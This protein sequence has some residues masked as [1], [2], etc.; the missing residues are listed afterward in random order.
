ME[1][2]T[3][4]VEATDL[5][6]QL[7]ETNAKLNKLIDADSAEKAAALVAEDAKKAVVTDVK[8]RMPAT[9]FVAKE[10]GADVHDIISKRAYVTDI[11][12]KR[13]YYDDE[14][15]GYMHLFGKAMRAKIHENKQDF[16]KFKAAMDKA[17]LLSCTIT[18][19]QL[20]ETAIPGSLWVYQELLPTYLRARDDGTPYEVFN[21]VTV[22]QDT[23]RLP[24][25]LTVPTFTWKGEKEKKDV[26]EP[27]GTQLTWD[28]NWLAGIMLYTNDLLEDAYSV[29]LTQYMLESAARGMRNS[30]WAATAVGNG[31]GQPTGYENCDYT[32]HEVD[33]AGSLTYPI[34]KQSWLTLNHPYRTAPSTAWFCNTWGLDAILDVVDHENRPVYGDMNPR[35]GAY[36]TPHGRPI[37][38]NE[39]IATDADSTPDVTSIY[40]IDTA[41]YH[42]FKRAGAGIRIDYSKDA[43]VTV[44]STDY[45]LFQ[46]NMGA[47]R[48]ED[49]MDMN[50]SNLAARM[51]I[52][53]VAPMAEYA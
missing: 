37:Y 50:C 41:Y 47:I 13:H 23:G 53:N 20:T 46:Q 15:K 49:R 25:E 48:F 27:T 51:R 45:N 11:Y 10:L 14:E 4:K 16:D 44:G 32:G 34:M 36:P 22:G 26:V 21:Q 1:D 7:A 12:N 35:S 24:Y 6:K 18:Q 28:L 5:E 31:A 8:E 43:I 17:A 3:L 30:I 42:I 40:L 29:N 33:A 9:L 38:I 19:K 39:N 52:I 2:V